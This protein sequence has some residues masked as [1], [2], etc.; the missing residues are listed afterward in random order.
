MFSSIEPCAPRGR[1]FPATFFPLFV[2]QTRTRI[3]PYFLP[4][5]EKIACTCSQTATQ[6]APRSL[7]LFV[8]GITV[9]PHCISVKLRD[10]CA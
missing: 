5:N 10:S 6:S 7:T 8:L 2:P 9:D 4:A 1:I 3:P